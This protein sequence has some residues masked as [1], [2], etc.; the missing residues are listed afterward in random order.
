VLY[1]LYFNLFTLWLNILFPMLCE[2]FIYTIVVERVHVGHV[3]DLC[4]ASSGMMHLTWTS[5]MRGSQIIQ[6][7]LD[8]LRMVIVVYYLMSVFVCLSFII[9]VA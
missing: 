6:R 4:I 3:V 2:V 5:K 7:I 8:S 1:V 9:S